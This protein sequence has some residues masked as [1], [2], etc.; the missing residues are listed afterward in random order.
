VF[1]DIERDMALQR[2]KLAKL[3]KDAPLDLATGD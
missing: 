1:A 2:A 3:P